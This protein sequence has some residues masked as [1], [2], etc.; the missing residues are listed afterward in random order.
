M[1][2][3]LHLDIT[4]G[5]QPKFLWINLHVLWQEH[6]LALVKLADRMDFKPSQE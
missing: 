1:L 4:L 3:H 6:N 5:S 2:E